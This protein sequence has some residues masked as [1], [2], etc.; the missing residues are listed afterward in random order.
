M[1]TAKINPNGFQR[2]AP[3]TSPFKRAR[4]DRVDPH[5]GQGI[6]VIRLNKQTPNSPSFDALRL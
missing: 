4:T 1:I 6:L 5:E 3:K 2:K